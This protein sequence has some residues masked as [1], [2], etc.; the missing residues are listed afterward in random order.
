MIEIKYFTKFDIIVIYNII[1]IKKTTNEKLRF[2]R[3]INITNIILCYSNSQ[4]FSQ[5]FKII[6][7]QCFENISTFSR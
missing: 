6:L 3:N 4:M 2:A 1:Q 7:T 5:F